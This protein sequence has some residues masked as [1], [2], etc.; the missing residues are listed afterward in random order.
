[1]SRILILPAALTAFSVSLVALNGTLAHA[2]GGQENFERQAALEEQ[3][4]KS[5]A[6]TK[7]SDEPTWFDRLFSIE[8]EA[9]ESRTKTPATPTST[10]TN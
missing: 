8:T 4:R 1:M 3:F 7:T 10:G 9:N 2:K 6:E 5:R